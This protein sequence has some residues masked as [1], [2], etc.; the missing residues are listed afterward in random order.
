V[1]AR[2]AEASGNIKPIHYYRPIPLSQLDACTNV[3]SCPA[4]QDANGVL[5]YSATADGFWQ[6]PGY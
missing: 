3:I 1:K 2:N 6:N 5:Q 4:S